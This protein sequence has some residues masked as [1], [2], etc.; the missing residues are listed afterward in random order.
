MGLI[1]V[2]K[3]L[4]MPDDEEEDWE[5]PLEAAKPEVPAPKQTQIT[6]VKPERYEQAEQIVRGLRASGAVVLDLKQTPREL[7]LRLADYL[8]GA[9][10]ALDARVEKV[11]SGVWFVTMPGVNLASPPDALLFGGKESAPNPV[12]F[13][14]TEDE[15]PAETV[16]YQYETEWDRP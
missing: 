5:Q 10:C 2:L 16:Q 4:S 7:L 13:R 9:V 6:V 1:D 15:S 3:Q 8:N 12:E 11:S 14:N